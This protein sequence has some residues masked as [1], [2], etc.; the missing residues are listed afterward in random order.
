M[1]RLTDVRVSCVDLDVLAMRAGASC[2]TLSPGELTRASSY[3]SARDRARFIARRVALRD[4]LAAQLGCQAVDLVFAPGSNGK[5]ELDGELGGAVHFN[6]SHS[7]RLALYALAQGRRVGI[8]VERVRPV[9]HLAEI[10]RRHFTAREWSV[11][12]AGGPARRMELFFRAWTLKEAYLKATG[13]GLS[14]APESVEL[15]FARDG[16]PQ[17]CAVDGDA[18]V[19]AHWASQTLAP[20]PGYV[21]GIVIEAHRRPAGG[22]IARA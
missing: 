1:Q 12:D 3:C 9:A 18:G 15:S 6:C 10:G 7:S 19:A 14:R 17:L 13:E 2:E 20:A 11:I 5:P 4:L 8:D 16:V 22:D 21:G